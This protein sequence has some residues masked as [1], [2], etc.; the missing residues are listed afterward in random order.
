MSAKFLSF[1]ACF[2]LPRKY[3]RNFCRQRPMRRDA[4]QRGISSPDTGRY[5]MV[6]RLRGILPFVVKLSVWVVP[7]D[8]LVACGMWFR[9]PRRSIILPEWRG[10][11]KTAKS[12]VPSRRHWPDPSHYSVVRKTNGFDE[13]Y[14]RETCISD[15]HNMTLMFTFSVVNVSFG[16]LGRQGSWMNVPRKLMVCGS[17]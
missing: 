11:P 15:P 10:R 1:R 17:L 16:N 8:W 2:R 4:G 12:H 14:E 3:H 6:W 5:E 9:L 7:D 13:V